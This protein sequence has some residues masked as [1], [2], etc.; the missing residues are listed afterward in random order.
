MRRSPISEEGHAF[1]MPQHWWRRLEI[2]FPQ[3]S[4]GEDF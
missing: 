4:P 1:E 3:I 2:S